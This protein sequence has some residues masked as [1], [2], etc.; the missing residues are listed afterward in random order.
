MIPPPL[1]REDTQTASTE[2]ATMAADIP[3]SSLGEGDVIP[4]WLD[5]DPGEMLSKALLGP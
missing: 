3:G 4:L 1:L 5:C 2:P